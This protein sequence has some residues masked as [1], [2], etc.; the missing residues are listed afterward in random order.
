MSRKERRKKW[1]Q[2]RQKGTREGGVKTIRIPKEKGTDKSRGFAYIEFKD[3]I[4]H[5]IALR[6]HHTTM[7]GK[8]I[9]VEFTSPGSGKSE[10]RKEKLKQKNNALVKHKIPYRSSS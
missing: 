1:M 4:S 7:N 3:R 2:Q 6:L 8:K 10:K 5:G 9:N